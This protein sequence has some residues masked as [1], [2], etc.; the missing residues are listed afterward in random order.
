MGW[1]VKQQLM[2]GKRTR[3]WGGA[4]L[5]W[6]CLM[7]ATPKIPL[8]PKHH[9]YADM[10]NFLGVPN[11]LNVITNFPF[12][13]V[14]VLGF[15]LCL[16][17]NFFNIILRGELWGWAL[18]YAGTAGVAFGSAYHHLK[19]DDNRVMWDTFPM[20]IA[21]SSLFS[22]FMVERMGEKIGLSSLFALLLFAFLSTAYGITYNDLR[23]CMTFQL[24]PS[25]AIP[26]MMYVFQ[27]KYTHSRYWLFAA[28]IHVLA[29]F[30]G[31]ADKKIYRANRYIISG[32]SLEHLCL[33]IVPVLLSIMLMYRN[34][35]F[36]RLGDHK[37][38]P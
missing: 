15:V 14:G 28:G 23:L 27:P 9:R 10:R 11:T 26:G 32:H 38:R 2:R 33:A 5:C 3:V 6:L 37:E 34:M 35:K 17:R 12:L 8:S 1:V 25:V 18:F 29:K 13:V 31:V 36:Q 30:E 22:S 7:F 4:L 24:I 21:Y 16:Q 19:P 20:M